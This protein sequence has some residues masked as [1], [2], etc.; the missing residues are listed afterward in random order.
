VKG[1]LEVLEIC[2][3]AKAVLALAE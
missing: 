1:Y 3:L 2:S